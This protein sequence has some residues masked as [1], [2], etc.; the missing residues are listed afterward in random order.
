MGEPGVIR[1]GDV[2]A[3]PML[4]R[5]S[6]RLMRYRTRLEAGF[7]FAQRQSHANGVIQK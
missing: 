1:G 4:L 3:P 2:A 7:V 6:V 5:T